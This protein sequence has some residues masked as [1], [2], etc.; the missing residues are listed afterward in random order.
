MRTQFLVLAL[1]FSSLGLFAQNPQAPSPSTDNSQPD[2]R[3]PPLPFERKCG[4]GSNQEAALL[5]PRGDFSGGNLIRRVNPKYP[6]AALAAHIQGTVVLCA[7]I[8]KEG[9]VRNVRVLSGPEELVPS[10]IEAVGQWRY[11]PYRKNKEPVEVDSEIHVD[12]K[13]GR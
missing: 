13:L 8:D 2:K 5:S 4:V 3:N 11:Q 10:A 7:T 6:P 1:L 12:F 9:K